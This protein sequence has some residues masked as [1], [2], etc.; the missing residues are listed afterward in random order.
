VARTSNPD[1]ALATVV[2][3]LREQRGLTREVLAY[4]AGITTGSLAR[5]EL[6]QSTPGWDTVRSLAAALEISLRDLGAAVE[7]PEFAEQREQRAA[8]RRGTS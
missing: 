3:R 2:R 4:H 8:R 7:A 6:V 1:P 5:I